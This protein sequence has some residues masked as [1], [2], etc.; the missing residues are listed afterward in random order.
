MN[1]T[2]IR[3]GTLYG[4]KSRAADGSVTPA[5]VVTTDFPIEVVVEGANLAA[6]AAG[7][8]L[9]PDDKNVLIV[10][11]F[12]EYSHPD[13]LIGL[14]R[15]AR[16][17]ADRVAEGGTVSLGFNDDGAEGSFADVISVD[18]LHGLYFDVLAEAARR[19]HLANID[20]RMEALEAIPGVGPT[21]ADTAAG[22]INLTLDQVDALVAAAVR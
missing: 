20:R 21:R 19:A 12:A 2:D 14:E 10:A 9:S 13:T 11:T 3:T 7:G 15:H 17:V 22:T 16:Q 6:R 5:I 8:A 4:W 1:P 18:N